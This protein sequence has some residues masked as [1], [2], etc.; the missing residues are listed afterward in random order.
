MRVQ[1]VLQ[2]QFLE[3]DCQV[4]ITSYCKMCLRTAGLEKKVSRFLS[5][6]EL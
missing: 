3:T 6:Y 5:R 1:I 2:F 4:G